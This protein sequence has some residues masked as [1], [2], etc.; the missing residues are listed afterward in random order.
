MRVSH[1]IRQ[2]WLGLIAPLHLE[3][4]HAA[5]NRFFL[6]LTKFVVAFWS[7]LLAF[8]FCYWYLNLSPSHFENRFWFVALLLSCG[9]NAVLLLVIAFGIL[10]FRKWALSVFWL[11][12][13]LTL[14]TALLVFVPSVT[15]PDNCAACM[16]LTLPVLVFLLTPAFFGAY[17][18]D[19]K[20]FLL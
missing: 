18:S 20:R 19:N 13:G 7:L 14:L 4:Q 6:F 2:L 8:F 11:S 1:G 17:L 3:K 9:A 16:V 5:Q 10:L 15:A 12:Y